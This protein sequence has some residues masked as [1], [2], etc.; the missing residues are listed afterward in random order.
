MVDRESQNP[1]GKSLPKPDE[2]KRIDELVESFLDQLQSGEG[3]DAAGLAAKHPDLAPFLER[4]LAFVE[5]V[6]QAAQSVTER[7]SEMASQQIAA[8]G[9]L[10]LTTSIP[11]LGTPA[12]PAERTLRIHC[13]HCGCQI[14][15][16]EPNE[17]DVTCRV[18]GSTIELDLEK[19]RTQAETDRAKRIDRF[20]ILDVL[21]RGGFG[22]VYK[23]RDTQLNRL[24]ALKVPRAGYFV[25]P[26][27][28]QRFLREAR[29]TSRLRHPQIV[30]VHEIGREKNVPFIVSDL[31]EGITLA[32]LVSAQRVPFRRAA[33][34]VADVA[35]AVNYAHGQNVIHRD[36]KP[37]NILIDEQGRPYI[38]D[39]GLARLDEGEFTMTQDGQVIGTPAY[40]SPEQAAGDHQRV[41]ARSDVYSLGIIL[42]RL[43]CGELPFRGSR[44]MMLHQVI[45]VDPRPP[46]LHHR[47]RTARPGDHHPQ[48]RGQREGAS[49]CVRRRLGRGPPKVPERRAD[50]SP[51]GRANREICEMV[52]AEPFGRGPD[53]RN[54]SNAR[55]HLCGRNDL[56]LAR[57]H[58]RHRDEALPRQ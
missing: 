34:L 52:S 5:Q 43:L 44:R 32:D 57:I 54:R 28:E 46:P 3:A 33:E 45:H 27:E 21:G 14:Q 39:F 36:I 50:P 1:D 55:G 22:V 18:C 35:E 49:I 19:T 8:D 2:E 53:C 51:T 11:G 7:E 25:T 30:Q 42:Y 31:I 23:A 38:T 26:E 13:P 37:S 20:E 17:S 15:L 48:S 6:F 9:G 58:P 24:I 29:H 47:L 41:D 40:M 12:L 10:P 16:V 56:G 4:R